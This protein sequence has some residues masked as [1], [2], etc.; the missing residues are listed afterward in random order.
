MRPW[1]RQAVVAS[2]SRSGEEELEKHQAWAHRIGLGDQGRHAAQRINEGHVVVV[3]AID[4]I[5]DPLGHRAPRARADFSPCR[6]ASATDDAGGWTATSEEPPA[7]GGK[8]RARRLRSV[9]S[10]VAARRRLPSCLAAAVLPVQRPGEIVSRH[11]TRV[12][13]RRAHV[14]AATASWAACVLQLHESGYCFVSVKKRSAFNEH[15]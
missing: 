6:C 15:K 4:R 14:V 9:R 2:V 8:T 12:A 10:L 7:Q 13:S 1:R 3:R 11:G 5:A